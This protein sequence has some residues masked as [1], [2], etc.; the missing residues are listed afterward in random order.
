[1]R[2]FFFKDREAEVQ[3]WPAYADVVINVTMILLFYL[4]AQSTISSQ[5][6]A[7]MMEI[8]QRQTKLRQAVEKNIPEAMRKDVTI[9]EDG[10]LQRYTFADRVLFDSGQAR[11]KSSGE[12]ILE[13]IGRM[14]RSQVGS[15]SKI[16]IEG[17]TDDQ[18]IR[19]GFASNWE[20]S[21]ARATSVVRFLQDRSGIDPQL[22]S[23]TGYSQY[24][25]V[26][27]NDSDEG[28]SR[29]RRIEILVVYSVQEVLEKSRRA[30]QSNS[31]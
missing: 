3:V 22:L 26:E 10:N 6:S 31:N 24:H 16:Q 27:A 5:T 19:V 29:N 9:T 17:H 8:R 28:R 25:P 15:F 1:M 21:S 14:F 13:A 18:P 7:G 11:L 12:E 23:A 4:F 2:S 20:L 30:R